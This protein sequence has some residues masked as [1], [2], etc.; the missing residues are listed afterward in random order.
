M[1]TEVEITIKIDEIEDVVEK[2]NGKSVIYLKEPKSNIEW[3]HIYTI[4]VRNEPV[5]ISKRLFG[6]FGYRRDRIIEC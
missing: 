2:E 1:R 5:R 6:F 4:E 3:G